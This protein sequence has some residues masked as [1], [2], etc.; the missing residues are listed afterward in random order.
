MIITYYNVNIITAIFKHN[1]KLREQ[2]IKMN[3]PV[4]RC[5]SEV[6]QMTYEIRYAKLV[7]TNVS[8][9]VWAWTPFVG[10]VLQATLFDQNQLTPVL[11]T[12]PQLFARFASITNPLV[13]AYGHSKYR[14]VLISKL[15]YSMLVDSIRL[16]TLRLLFGAHFR[17]SKSTCTISASSSS[18]KTN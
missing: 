9:W 7:M 11:T 4:M 15:Y 8:L 14:L 13:L 17:L 16:L 2:A 3:V 18:T 1:S 10:I 6:I 5:N 12:V